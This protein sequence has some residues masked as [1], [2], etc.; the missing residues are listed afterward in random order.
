VLVGLGRADE[1]QRLL[2]ALRFLRGYAHNAAR[3]DHS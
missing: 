3:A 1:V 2:H